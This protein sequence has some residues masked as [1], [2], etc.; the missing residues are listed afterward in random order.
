MNF[1]TVGASHS[2]KDINGE[3]V[4]RQDVLTMVSQYEA[5]LKKKNNSIKNYMAIMDI[6][7]NKSEQLERLVNSYPITNNKMDTQSWQS[8]LKYRLTRGFMLGV[9]IVSPL[10][11]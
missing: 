5:E 8:E 6:I 11:L 9:G 4:K 7:L 1:Y 2:A 10:I 3:W